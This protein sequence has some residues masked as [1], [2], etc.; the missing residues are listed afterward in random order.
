MKEARQAIIDTVKLCVPMAHVHWHT[1]PQTQIPA[2]SGVDIVINHRLVEPVTQ[3]DL[4][5]AYDSAT[6]DDQWTFLQDYILHTDMHIEALNHKIFTASDIAHRIQ[7]RIFAP[8]ML[9]RLR[10]AL[11]VVEAIDGFNHLPAVIDDREYSGGV[12]SIR[13]RWLDSYSPGVD[14][15]GQ[16]EFGVGEFIESVNTNNIIPGP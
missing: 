14:D 16:K 15:T 12:L 6:D 4:R 8:A 7:T 3:L 1:E 11:V 2:T 13:F 10:Q 9:D 5:R